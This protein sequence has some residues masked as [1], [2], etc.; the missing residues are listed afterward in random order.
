MLDDNSELCRIGSG[1][2]HTLTFWVSIM[3]MRDN[4]TTSAKQ[5]QLD[6]LHK[7]G[8]VMDPTGGSMIELVRW[9]SDE[10]KKDSSGSAVAIDVQEDSEEPRDSLACHVQQTSRVESDDAAE[11]A[12]RDRTDR[13]IYWVR[14]YERLIMILNYSVTA[15]WQIQ[16]LL[17]V[18]K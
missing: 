17:L 4:K 2:S 16:R 9:D 7:Q 12:K 14:A 15:H 13:D 3:R 1:Q 11:R 18:S 6:L 8:A 5:Y 10:R